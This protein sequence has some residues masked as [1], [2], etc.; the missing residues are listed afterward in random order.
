MKRGWKM[1]LFG[2]HKSKWPNFLIKMSELS[3]NNLRNVFSGR[4]LAENST[5]RKFRIVQK[6][7]KSGISREIDFYNLDVIISVGYRVKSL[8]GTQFRIWATQ[9]LREY[10]IKGFVMDDERLAEGRVKKTYFE[11]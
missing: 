11:E 10:I 6:K 2:F 9:K 3:M 5:V 8:R 1:R 4:E 7:G